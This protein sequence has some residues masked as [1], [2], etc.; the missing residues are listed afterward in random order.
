VSAVP[1]TDEGLT[2]V[3]A[4]ITFCSFAVGTVAGFGSVV[5]TLSL[6]VSL[7]L[8]VNAM[9]R[10][11]VPLNLGFYGALA[12]Q[13]R[14]SLQWATLARL[15]GPMLPGLAVG[16]AVSVWLEPLALRRFFGLF[17]LLLGAW[18]VSQVVRG[19]VPPALPG[20][21][22]VMLL[23][24]AGVVQGVF[25]SAGPLVVFVAGRE[26]KDRDTFRATL[27]ALW[28]VLNLIALPRFLLAGGLS[29]ATLGLV[30]VMSVPVV[31]GVLVGTRLQRVVSERAFRALVAGLMV[32]MALPL[33]WG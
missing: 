21:L 25:S 18:Q 20:G 2:A 16:L 19:R 8:D 32:V 4:L 13:G 3:L 15:A 17:V 10:W 9:M 29:K 24:I 27:N 31:A 6:G 33:L 14:A 26:L 28:F 11:L 5:L 1:V 22:R 30:G 23:V 7:G 12:F